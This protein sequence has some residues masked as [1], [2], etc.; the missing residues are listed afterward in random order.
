MGYIN[1]DETTFAFLHGRQYA[2]AGEAWNRAVE[3]WNSIAS[4]PG[5]MAPADFA[6]LLAEETERWR[7]VAA[8]GGIERQ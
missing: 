5:G 6:G 2:P 7:S 4:D 1:P 8:S 3:W